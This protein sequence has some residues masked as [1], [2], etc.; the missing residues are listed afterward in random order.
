VARAALDPLRP[1]SRGTKQRA[2]FAARVSFFVDMNTEGVIIYPS[3]V[4]GTRYGIVLTQSGQFTCESRLPAHP[5]S[6]KERR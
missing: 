1:E 3:M 6:K 4:L 5:K 2:V